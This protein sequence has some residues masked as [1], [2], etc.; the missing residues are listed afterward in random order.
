MVYGG[1][2][3]PT[4]GGAVPD[5][6][7]VYYLYIHNYIHSDNYNDYVRDIYLFKAT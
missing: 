7:Y 5:I 4:W 2:Q 1:L 3:W 6:L